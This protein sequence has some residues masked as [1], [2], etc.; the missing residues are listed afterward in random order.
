MKKIIKLTESELVKIIKR[1]ISEQPILGLASSNPV[2]INLSKTPQ[3][4]SSRLPFPETDASTETGINCKDRQLP[5]DKI[6]KQYFSY[7]NVNKSKFSGSLSNQQ[8]YLMQD[9][10]KSMDGVTSTGT[11][12]ILEKIPKLEDFCKIVINFNY[13][14]SQ[15]GNDLW[16]WLDDEYS[17]G[18]LDV[19]FALRKFEKE[20]GL[21]KCSEQLNNSNFLS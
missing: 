9:L 8:K 16:S 17:I 2:R 6:A 5:I 20:I 15:G 11:L 1:V 4:G 12:E 7:C 19:H 14:N 10:H 18:W 21:I 3:V 13:P